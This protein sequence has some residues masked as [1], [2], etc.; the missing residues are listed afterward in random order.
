MPSMRETQEPDVGLHRVLDVARPRAHD[1]ATSERRPLC[2]PTAGLGHVGLA[3]PGGRPP[4]RSVSRRDT[5]SVQGLGDLGEGLAS[6]E[7]RPDLFPPSR[8]TVVAPGV[9]KSNVLGGEVSAGRLCD[10]VVVRR[11]RPLGARRRDRIERA[12]PLVVVALRHLAL[13]GE[14][15][16][17]LQGAR[18]ETDR[19]RAAPNARSDGFQRCVSRFCFT[20]EA[21]ANALPALWPPSPRHR[22]TTLPWRLTMH[23]TAHSFRTSGGVIVAEEA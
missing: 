23:P 4:L 6:R 1:A 9:G 19:T 11:G 18:T 3:D 13:Q 7:H 10:R 20:R 15:L 5:L 16:A 17:A 2:C 21:R 8:V 22:S 12:A 14:E